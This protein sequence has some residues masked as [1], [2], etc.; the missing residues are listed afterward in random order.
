MDD[1]ELGPRLDRYHPLILAMVGLGVGLY[2]ICTAVLVSVDGTDYINNARKIPNSLDTVL[3]KETFG[4]SLLIYLC[5]SLAFPSEEGIESWIYAARIFNLVCWI[6]ACLLLYRIAGRW[7]GARQSFL[8]VLTLVLLPKPAWYAADVFRDWPFLLFLIAG[9]G[10]LLAGCRR[11]RLSWFGLA[12][13]LSG[14]A[15][16]I[17]VEGVQIVMLGLMALGVEGI[18]RTT[19]HS[20]AKLVTAG[21]LLIVGFGLVAGWLIAQQGRVVPDKLRFQPEMEASSAGLP[22][23][24]QEPFPP[25]LAVSRVPEWNLKWVITTPYVLL[26]DISRTMTWHFLIIGLVGLWSAWRGLKGNTTARF[27]IVLWGGFQ[28]VMLTYLH[29]TYGYIGRRHV[30]PLIAALCVVVPEGA[31]RIV[32]WFQGRGN[33]TA[34]SSKQYNPAWILLGVMIAANLPRLVTP[35]HGDKQHYR[36]V[37]RWLADHTPLDAL[38]MVDD[39]RIGFYADRRYL[40]TSFHSGI[41]GRLWYWVTDDP[42]NA[43]AIS[44]RDGIGQRT[45]FF[46]DEKSGDRIDVFEMTTPDLATRWTMDDAAESTVI[47][48]SADHPYHGQTRRNTADLAV[49]GKANGAIAFNGSTDHIAFVDSSPPLPTSWTIAMWIRYEET[50]NPTLISFGSSLSSIRLQ[51]DGDGRPLLCMWRKNFRYFS[52]T[53]LEILRDGNWHHIAFTMPGAEPDSIQSAR[54]YVDGAEMGVETTRATGPQYGKRQLFLGTNSAS[55]TYRFRGAM[56]EVRLYNRE[57]T[58]EEI[59]RLARMDS[60]D[61]TEETIRNPAGE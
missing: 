56:D 39:P 2:L 24:W 22:G 36:Q 10:A 16:W 17:R 26:K 28:I 60:C 44:A 52:V 48:D 32:S 50:P 40:L 35:L 9:M 59:A 7:V 47:T 61:W 12:G 15:Y 42:E 18:V 19:G 25:I 54:M 6:G 5:H 55:G 20:R 37:S 30:L 46:A 33:R 31:E 8:G 34:G 45:V 11:G 41:P 13:L 1:K 27:W 58:G 57:L 38:L 4:Y 29:G 43:A 51:S 23:Q 49:P 53:A 21:A 3:P 14:A